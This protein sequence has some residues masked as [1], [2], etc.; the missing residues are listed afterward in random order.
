MLFADEAFFAGDR[1]HE[2]VLKALIT[3]PTLPIEGKYMDVV[4]VRNMLHVYMSSNS[5]WVVPATHDERR[6]FVRDVLDTRVG[7]RPYFNALYKEMEEGGLAAMIYD[8][9]NARNISNFDPRDV[10]KTQAL[11]DQQRRSLDSLDRWGSPCSNAALSGAA[12]SGSINSPS[13]ANSAPQSFLNGPTSNGVPT[14]GRRA[15]KVAS[16]LVS[17]CPKCTP[18]FAPGA[19][20][21]SARWKPG[22]QGSPKSNS[23]SKPADDLQA[24]SSIRSTRHAPASPRSAV[25]PAIGRSPSCW[26]RIRWSGYPPNPAVLWGG[27]YA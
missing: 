18:E 21:S 9:L 1:Q 20:R 16:P 14:H 25:S 17:E 8:M 15:Q 13:G 22:P 23:S 6:Y 7:D 12:A 10:P 26:S 19:I 5:D 3:E 2:S 24:T 27:W 4:F 11:V